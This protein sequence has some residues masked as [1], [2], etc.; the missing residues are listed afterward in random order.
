MRATPE[1][2]RSEP[3]PAQAPARKTLADFG[4][5]EGKYTD[6]LFSEAEKRAEAV[7][8]R[9]VKE[10]YQRTSFQDRAL[11]FQDRARE[12]A[13]AQ[14]VEDFEIAFAHPSEG[15]PQVTQEMAETI[16]EAENGP[17]MLYHL[18]KNRDLA[19]Q[20]SRL[21]PLQQAREL[22]RLEARLANKPTAAKVSAAPPPAPKVEGSASSTPIAPDSPDSDKLSAEEWA[23]RRNKQLARR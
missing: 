17:E 5:D 13:K 16:L 20:I 9:K 10:T 11:D 4:Y 19:R 18:A 6:Y 2:V 1:P 15:G 3:E 22:G 23:R 12:Y 8:E 7:A 14:K 21:P